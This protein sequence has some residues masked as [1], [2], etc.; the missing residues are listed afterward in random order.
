PG[1]GGEHGASRADMV[2]LTVPTGQS[3]EVPVWIAPGH[4]DGAVTLHLGY[5]R[6]RAG[7]VGTG[8]G[9]DADKLRTTAAPSVV[10]DVQVAR[11]GKSYELA[12]TQA[13]FNVE[14]R[15]II[16]HATEEEYR[17][18]PDF[19]RRAEEPSPGGARDSQGTLPTP[20]PGRADPGK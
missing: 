3:L 2:R 18:D 15:G 13:H 1:E 6:T 7:R 10:R 14:G 8:R 9:F 17:N 16:R 12:C 19:A 5:G 11:T 4:A 20:Q